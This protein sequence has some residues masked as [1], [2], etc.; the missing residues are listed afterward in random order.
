MLEGANDEEQLGVSIY[1][2]GTSSKLQISIIYRS[3][4]PKLGSEKESL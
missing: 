2:I 4:C 1:C 3:V